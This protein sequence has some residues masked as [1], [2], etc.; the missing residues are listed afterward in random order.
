MSN[1]KS[2][3]DTPDTSVSKEMKAMVDQ[4][5][6]LHKGNDEIRQDQY[7]SLVNHYYDL[8]TD[9]YE[10]GWGKSFHFAPRKRGEA[11]KDAILRHQR[12]LSEKLSLRSGLEAIDL[13]CGV[14]GPMSNLARWTGA[15]IVG[16]NNNK[17][18]LG[19]ARSN[20]EHVSDLCQFLHADFMKIPK[21]NE[22]F[23]VAYAIEALVHAPKR[24]DAFHEIFRVLRPG[25]LFAGYEWCMTDNYD[26]SN[27][28]HD[29][30]KRDIMIGNGLPDIETISDINKGLVD[31]GFEVIESRDLASDSDPETPWFLA[32][33]GKDFSLSSIARTPFGRSM[34]NFTLRIA[35]AL[36]L[37]PQGS[38][39]VSTF[40]NIGA[41]ALVK[42]GKTD[43]FTPMYF[44]LA[45]KPE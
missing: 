30:I 31:A 37:V 9:F 14:G 41:D 10:F 24:V 5:I 8:S 25:G 11:L 33:Q 18:Q 28:E 45:R 19:R 15:N 26:P 21:D 17:K 2:N 22:S 7:E 6:K 13:G 43:T 20:T 39:A 32:L 40:L 38:R 23:D 42:G 44:I 1:T 4:Y 29:Q 34:T 12:F 35:E 27:P 36:R 16:L 3:H